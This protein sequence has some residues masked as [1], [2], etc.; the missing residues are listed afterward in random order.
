VRNSVKAVVDAYDGTVTF[1][2]VDDQ[3]PIIAAYR[4]AF[5]ELFADGSEVSEELRAHFRYPEDLFRVQ[6]NM[7][8]AYHVND[9]DD[10]LNENDAW[11][12]AQSPGNEVAAAQPGRR[13][14]DRPRR[15]THQGAALRAVLPGAP[16][17]R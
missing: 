10:F 7:W 4:Q 5:P 13:P 15:R 14:G 3:D 8:G 17:P 16:A 6:T 1:Y 9:P 12:V 2:V 11:D